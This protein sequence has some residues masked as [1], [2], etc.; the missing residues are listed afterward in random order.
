MFPEKTEHHSD[1]ACE[2]DESLRR[3]R[4]GKGLEAPGATGTTGS[5]QQVVYGRHEALSLEED[6]VIQGG[7][8]MAGDQCSGSGSGLPQGHDR[9]EERHA[10]EDGA[11]FQD[12]G[13]RRGPAR[14]L[15]SAS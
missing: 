13:R 6:A 5:Q 2:E 9:H 3:F 14:P 12:L 7:K 10:E 1:V 15:R 11:G 4:S 8:R